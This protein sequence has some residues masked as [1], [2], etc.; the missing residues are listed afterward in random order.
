MRAY[1]E[2]TYY[3]HFVNE[4][5]LIGPLEQCEE[6]GSSELLMPSQTWRPWKLENLRSGSEKREPGKTGNAV[7]R[8][9]VTMRPMRILIDAEIVHRAASD[10]QLEYL[11]ELLDDNQ[12]ECFQFADEGP[13]PD[14]PRL[15]LNNDWMIADGWIETGPSQWPHVLGVF[16]G[17][18]EKSWKTGIWREDPHFNLLPVA[19]VPSAYRD[20]TDSAAKMRADLITLLIADQIEADLFV[21]ERPFLLDDEFRLAR[22]TTIVHPYHALPIVGLYLRMQNRYIVRRSHYVVDFLETPPRWMFFWSAAHHVLPASRTWSSVCSVQVSSVEDDSLSHLDASLHQRI[23]GGLDARDRLLQ[24]LSVPQGNQSGNDAL[25]YLTQICLWLMGAFDVAA[26]VTDRCLSLNTR[27]QQIAWQRADWQEKVA[28]IDPAL[29]ALVRSH[30][31][32]AYLLTIVR[33]IRNS[34]HGEVLSSSGYKEG[35]G[36][37]ESL[38][39][40]PRSREAALLAAI[41]ALG[42]RE[43]WG[44]KLLPPVGLSL[45]PGEFLEELITRSFRL[46]NSIMMAT[47]APR[48]PSASVSADTDRSEFERKYPYH[49]MGER[50]GNRIRWQLG[51]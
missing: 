29:A 14:V 3:W 13:P 50:A 32:G 15:H 31:E 12:I 5:I 35:S 47:A 23:A 36:P 45:L 21:T 18:G 41:D 20:L 2:R 19:K 10:E 48:L 7:F 6:V 26:V 9:R 42:G 46:L 1:N 43:T 33:E 27:E 30:S 40:I 34:I 17:Q 49:P 39:G 22:F 16:V 11:L 8:Q 24:V 37:D 44:A 51:L 38:V 28:K 25:T 4:P